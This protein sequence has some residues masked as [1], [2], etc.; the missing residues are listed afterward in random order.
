MPT[1]NM[2]APAPGQAFPGMPSGTSY[3]ADNYGAVNGV[4][5]I[6]LLAMLKAGCALQTGPAKIVVAASGPAYSLLFPATGDVFYDVTLSTNCV[7]SVAPTSNAAPQI[8]RLIIRPNGFQ[9]TLPSDGATL[10]NVAGSPP[11]PS[12][13]GISEYTYASSGSAPL[14]GGV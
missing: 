11:V 9:A 8:M 7:F 10:V 4:A 5:A 14:L 2:I 13:T 3:T 6:D 12:T 1:S